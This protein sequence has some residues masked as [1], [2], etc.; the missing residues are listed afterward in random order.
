MCRIW[1]GNV[2]NRMV[3]CLLFRNYL[4]VLVVINVIVIRYG[5]IRLN[6]LDL[7]VY[8]MI[9]YVRIGLRVIRL[10]WMTV[11]DVLILMCSLLIICR[12]RT[13]V[14]SSRL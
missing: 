11:V 12:V 8:G 10:M 9:L 5:R 4:M 1:M 14:Y 3:V 13:I 2:I 7:R 6:L